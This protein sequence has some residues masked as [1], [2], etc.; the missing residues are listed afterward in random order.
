MR[1]FIACVVKD[2]RLFFSRKAA[3]LVLVLPI[4]LLAVLVP[5]FSETTSART[6][7]RPFRFVICDLDDSVMSRSLINQLRQFELFEE[8]ASVQGYDDSQTWFDHG[9][10][11]YVTVPKGFFYAMYDMDNLAVTIE[12]NSEMPAE[13]AILKA[14]FSSVTDI[15]AAE[16]KA[17]LAE[18]RMQIAAGLEPDKND[19]FYESANYE[20]KR[21]LSR[22][23][24]FSDFL[25]IED[26]TENSLKAAYATVTAMLC[27]LIPL[28]ML[29]GLPEEL[30]LGIV[31]RLKCSGRG[32]LTLIFSKYFAALVLLLLPFAAV[33]AAVGLVFPP[34]AYFSAFMLFTLAFSLFGM[35]SIS[36]PNASKAQLIGNITVVLFLLFGGALYPYQMLPRFAQKAA[37]ASPVFYYLRGINGLRNSAFVLAAAA[38][39]LSVVFL[40]IC[41]KSLRLELLPVIKRTAADKKD[42]GALLKTGKADVLSIIW[43]KM[44]AMT[45]RRVM[46]II[47]LA[48]SVLCFFTVDR[49]LDEKSSVEIVIAVADS[50]NTEVS[51]EYIGSLESA[52]GVRVIK[53]KGSEALKVLDTGEAEAVLILEDGFEEAFL[54]DDALPVKFY[55]ASAGAASDAGREICAGRLLSMQSGYDAL[56]RL[57]SEGVI[58]RD[59]KGLFFEQLEKAEAEA[60]P[61]VEF[62][63]SAGENSSEKTVY[64][65]IYARY[66]GFAALIVFLFIMSLS[67]LLSGTSAGAV[68]KAMSAAPGGYSLYVITDLL[69]L[70]LAGVFVAASALIFRSE[71]DI[72]EILAYLLY[73]N[74][75]AGL[76]LVLSLTRAGGGAD[77]TASILAMVTSA[78]G[79]CFFD[80]SSLG[81]AFK[82]ITYFTPQGLLIG[83]VS[84]SVICFV[85]M[86]AITAV[87]LAVYY[88]SCKRA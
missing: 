60:K 7:V 46:L 26:Y 64:G 33:S 57:I 59:E 19:L 47:M 77:M 32:I 43:H 49:V 23:N 80:L 53:N 62:R 54:N 8:V 45:G 20:L 70:V 76:C 81:G 1:S 13:S 22:R 4:L 67:V 10:A 79:G 18:F 2:V 52:S 9:Y 44:L 21:A 14:V 78:A 6:Y 83:A 88:Y 85:A 87:C 68:R 35:I 16:Q 65:R 11:A 15:V 42:P 5:G 12:F 82:T 39:A 71:A 24:V 36:T 61:I 34:S 31:D 84:G 3:V 73:V 25:L 27:M 56:S 48:V 50:D 51:R 69:A 37:H 75:V 55:S 86:A 40:V 72:G 28:C 58:T 74:C 66:S 38:V 29:R 30:M 63:N 41:R 17:R